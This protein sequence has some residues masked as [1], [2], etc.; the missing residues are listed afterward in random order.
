[1]GQPNTKVCLEYFPILKYI[2]LKF[3][4]LIFKLGIIG[5]NSE[6]VLLENFFN[7]HLMEKEG[8]E[9]HSSSNV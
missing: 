7:I 6:Q 3:F 5:E 8:Y 4:N 9:V 2:I 1:M